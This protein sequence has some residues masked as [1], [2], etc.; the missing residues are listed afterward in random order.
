MFLKN[1]IKRDCQIR[2]FKSARP[3]AAYKKHTLTIKTQ[4]D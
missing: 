1:L 2:F 4:I 3:Y